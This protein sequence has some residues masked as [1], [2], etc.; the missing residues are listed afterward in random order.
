MLIPNWCTLAELHTAIQDLFDW[1]NDHLHEFRQEERRFE[2]TDPW[3]FVEKSEEDEILLKSVLPRKSSKLDYTYDFGDRWEHRIIMEERLQVD[4]DL[5]YP[6][7]VGGKRASPPDDFGGIWRYNSAIS[8]LEKATSSAD[9]RDALDS[10]LTEL[11]G[12]NFDPAH[13]DLDEINRR[14]D[15]WDG[16]D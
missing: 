11:F 9:G 2:A 3:E 12:E 10:D 15:P 14:L 7:C 16:E 5:D 1:D 4:L 6:T 13:F 8:A